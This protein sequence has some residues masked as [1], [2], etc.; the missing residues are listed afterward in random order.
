M[1]YISPKQFKRYSW[2]GRNSKVFSP[3]SRIW[4]KQERQ[5]GF[6]RRTLFNWRVKKQLG[7]ISSYLTVSR[8]QAKLE[9]A[10]TDRSRNR[11]YAPEDTA[12]LTQRHRQLGHPVTIRKCWTKV[13]Y[14]SNGVDCWLEN[15][16]YSHLLQEFQAGKNASN[17]A[18]I[19][20]IVSM[21]EFRNNYVKDRHIQGSHEINQSRRLQ[22]L[23]GAGCDP[24]HPKIL[25]P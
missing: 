8:N 19:G 10:N 1:L 3:A 22:T 12:P 20:K 17:R 15:G 13:L 4:I 6:F 2:L 11:S 21:G 16:R 14:N 9:F 24:T 7:R 23:T 25:R 18:A 5:S